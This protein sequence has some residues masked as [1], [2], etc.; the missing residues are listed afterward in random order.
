[1]DNQKIVRI[2]NKEEYLDM[3]LDI[4]EKYPNSPFYS[5]FKEYQ[6][7]NVCFND[8]CTN[9][10]FQLNFEQFVI[11]YNYVSNKYHYLDAPDDIKILMDKFNFIDPV[12]IYVANQIENKNKK[13]YAEILKN[14]KQLYDKFDIF[15]SKKNTLLTMNFDEYKVYKDIFSTNPNI[16]PVQI[17]LNKFFMN[18]KMSIDRE[19]MA[20]FIQCIHIYDGLPLY[21][22]S[23]YP[24]KPGIFFLENEGTMSG[25]NRN[26]VR[27]KM[28]HVCDPLCF[29]GEYHE[30]DEMEDF[31]LDLPTF[32]CN[33]YLK[34]RTENDLAQNWYSD[35]M[36]TYI[37]TY[38]TINTLY[39]H[40]KFNYELFSS[41]SKKCLK[42]DKIIHF[43]SQDTKQMF[44]NIY[45]IITQD[46]DLMQQMVKYDSMDKSQIIFGFIQ[47]GN[48]VAES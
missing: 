2:I 24:D 26:I 22:M 25:I 6:T 17:I 42:S 36:S 43:C 20:F 9:L 32:S 45:T 44:R 40:Y 11:M 15:M 29:G 47:L 16:I 33:Y 21:H 39:S 19:K 37:D 30:F 18:T 5:Y 31:S 38:I 48:C 13:L 4:I 14:S 35:D 23:K 41:A 27:E 34:I 7:N 1:M 3:S 12:L 46:P 10:D 28:F 8:I